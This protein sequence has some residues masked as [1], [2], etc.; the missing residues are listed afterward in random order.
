MIC[1]VEALDLIRE[2]SKDLP[3]E[4]TFEIKSVGE[5]L[6]CFV[7]LFSMK[8]DRGGRMGSVRANWCLGRYW[9]IQTE[10]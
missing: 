9:I 7:S 6:F 3:K 8:L 4:I 1:R 5:K 10:E 2:L